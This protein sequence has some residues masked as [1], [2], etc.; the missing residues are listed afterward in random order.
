MDLRDR[1]RR[2]LNAPFRLEWHDRHRRRFLSEYHEMKAR[3][4]AE[5]YLIGGR[6]TW[7]GTLPWAGSPLGAGPGVEWIIRYHPAHPA[8]MPSVHVLAPSEA[9]AALGGDGE[10]RVVVLAPGGWHGAL[11]AYDLWLWLRAR[12]DGASR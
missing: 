2:A 8:V 3:A 11:T 4:G 9:V 12:V 7:A 5:L 6:L 10:G 1:L